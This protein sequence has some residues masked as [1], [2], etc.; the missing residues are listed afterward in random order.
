MHFV[1][2]SSIPIYCL[3]IAA[4]QAHAITHC[5]FVEGALDNLVSCIYLGP[6]NKEWTSVLITPKK[7]IAS[8]IATDYLATAAMLFEQSPY[9]PTVI[10]VITDERA[11]DSIQVEGPAVRYPFKS[12]NPDQEFK[13]GIK[14]CRIVNWDPVCKPL[15]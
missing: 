6:Q 14:A 13:K 3:L 11:G 4:N 15:R 12:A 8:K 1:R 10:S 9:H 7:R 2:F 5:A